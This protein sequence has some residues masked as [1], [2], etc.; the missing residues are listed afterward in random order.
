MPAVTPVTT[1]AASDTFVLLLLH[2]P[3]GVVLFNVVVR[4]THTFIVP[5]I[6]SGNGF[7]VT[8]VVMIQPVAVSI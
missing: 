3:P 8:G 4:P 7:T 5:V 2:A 6:A 1:L